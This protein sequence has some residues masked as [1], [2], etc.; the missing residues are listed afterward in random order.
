MPLYKNEFI[1]P[2]ENDVIRIIHHKVGKTDTINISQHAC[3]T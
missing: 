2:D 1:L 3:V